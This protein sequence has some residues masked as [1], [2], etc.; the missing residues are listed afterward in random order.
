MPRS[1][2]DYIV[3]HCSKTKPD[4]LDDKKRPFDARSLDRKHRLQGKLS[5]GY[6]YVIER[7]GAVVNGRQ[8]TEPGAHARGYNHCS[9]GICL[10]GGLPSCEESITDV[11]RASL[12]RL[13][14]V[15]LSRYPG[16]L[17]CGHSDLEGHER[18]I[19]CPGFN[20]KEWYESGSQDREGNLG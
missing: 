9:I 19:N 18:N 10:I 12:F 3:V 4:E 6:H 14:G 17:V 1:S 13:L 16:V 7:S 8:C 15:L 11:Q 20:V 2:T 5:L